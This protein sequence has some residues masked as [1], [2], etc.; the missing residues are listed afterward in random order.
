[1]GQL[2][3]QLIL[4]RLISVLEME[5]IITT[6]LTLEH[7]VQFLVYALRMTGA[8]EKTCYDIANFT[9]N[10]RYNG[11][12]VFAD[13]TQ[14]FNLKLRVRIIKPGKECIDFTN[15]HGKGWHDYDGPGVKSIE[16]CIFD[17][18]MMVYDEK[19]PASLFYIKNMIIMIMLMNMD[20]ILKQG[21]RLI[22]IL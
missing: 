9:Y 11:L 4:S 8:D 20:G 3:F 7:K 6:C 17:D 21:Q 10:R 5:I 16:L 1:M 15:P 13:I 12:S 18:H 22:A 2:C 14:N 19:I